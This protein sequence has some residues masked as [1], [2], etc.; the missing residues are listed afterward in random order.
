LI[1]NATPAGPGA[2]VT[3][4]AENADSG[5]FRKLF[6][7]MPSI[8]VV[9]DDDARITAYNRAAAGLLRDHAV[10]AVG[11]RIGE[12]IGCAHASESPDGCGRGPY[13]SRCILRNSVNDASTGAGAQRRRARL[14]LLNIG[15]LQEI[16]AL[17]TASPF[18]FNGASLVLLIVE[19]ISI[20]AE[21]TR[22][23]PICAEC[24][25]VRDG[26]DAWMRV[27][28]YFSREWGVDF[29][30]GMCP[31]CLSVQMKRLEER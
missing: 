7:S 8:A 27:E 10:S 11:T 18:E 19:D 17:V 9:V 29:S 23:I 30:H 15:E 31:E 12:A 28:S 24:G 6:D 26:G 1:G 21:L 5:M 4:V 14:Q 2:E 16:Y 13:C 20:I 22:I 3:F 25:K